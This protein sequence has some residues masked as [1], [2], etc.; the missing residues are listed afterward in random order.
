MDLLVVLLA[1]AVVYPFTVVI[2]AIHTSIATLAMFAVVPNLR[3][4]I[5]AEVFTAF[6]LFNRLPLRE[7]RKKTRTRIV[8]MIL[9]R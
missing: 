9:R 2:E 4:A 6:D 1:Y 5:V 8:S 7:T 3:E